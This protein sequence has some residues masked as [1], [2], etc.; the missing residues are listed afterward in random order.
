[1]IKKLHVSAGNGHHQVCFENAL[2]GAI[3]F[4]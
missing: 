1:L 3:Q 4:L 2:G